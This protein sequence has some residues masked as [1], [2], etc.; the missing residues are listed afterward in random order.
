M[1]INNL[2]PCEYVA[3][4]PTANGFCGGNLNWRRE[5]AGLVLLLL[6]K[7]ILLT[8]FISILSS[9]YPQSAVLLS[10]SSFISFQ[11]H[12]VLSHISPALP[13]N[14]VELILLVLACVPT[15]P[16]HPE[17]VLLSP[18]LLHLLELS[19]LLYL[20]FSLYVW[21]ASAFPSTSSLSSK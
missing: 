19:L 6:P 11:W 16:V 18:K 14:N 2:N 21:V 15:I 20:Q 1:W 13:V 12:T 10:P 8:W 9:C 7:A 5:T 4:L 17:F 3:A